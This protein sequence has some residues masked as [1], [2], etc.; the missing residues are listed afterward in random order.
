[1][2]NSNNAPSYPCAW[3]TSDDKPCLDDL[4]PEIKTALGHGSDGLSHI[5]APERTQFVVREPSPEDVADFQRRAGAFPDPIAR[6][7]QSTSSPDSDGDVF[8]LRAPV[9]CRRSLAV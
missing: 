5:R 8:E 9:E 6:S 4:W 3:H 1:M 2:S 7:D